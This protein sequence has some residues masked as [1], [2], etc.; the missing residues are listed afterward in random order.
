MGALS[1]AAPLALAALA[2]LPVIWWLLRVTPPAPQRLR[3]FGLRFLAGLKTE[4]E[5]PDKTPLW[6]L[7]LRMAAAAL[8]ILALA[9]PLM[10]ASRSLTRSDG[11]LILVVDNGWAAAHRWDERRDEMRGL[12]EEARRADLPV[13][14]APTASA[15]F[16]IRKE[17]PAD[18]LARAMALEPQPFRSD[19]SAMLARLSAAATGMNARVV[20]LADGIGDSDTGEIVTD[21]TGFGETA[22]YLDNDIAPAFAML[23]PTQDETGLTAHLLRAAPGPAL[24]GNVQAFGE[25]GRFIAAAPFSFASGEVK[26]EARIETPGALRNDIERLAVDSRASAGSVTLLDE[27]ARRRPVG[28]VSGDEG[29]G[30]Q[31]LLSA[32]YY[33]ERAFENAAEARLGTVSEHLDRGISMLVL[34]DVGQVTGEEETRLADWIDKGGVLIRFAGPRLAG[35]G[36]DD[37][38][39]VRLRQTGARALG[40]ALSWE[41]PQTLAPFPK[42]GPF[43]GLKAPD[44][45]AITRQVLAEP[46]LELESRTWAS[47]ADGTPLVTGVKRG[48]GWIVLFHITANAEWSNLPLS[49]LFVDMLKRLLSL[50]RGVG[51]SADQANAAGGSLNPRLVLDGFGRLVK[52]GA[53]VTPVPRGGAEIGPEHPPGLYGEGASTLALNLFAAD[54]TLMPF[55]DLPAGAS[56]HAYGQRTEI[57]FKPW[58]LGAALLLFFID[59]FASMMLRGYRFGIRRPTATTA[60]LILAAAIV[61][62]AAPP[63]HAQ[64]SDAAADEFALKAALQTHLA[65]VI[66]GDPELDR[67]SKEG[68]MGLTR[69]LDNRTAVSAGEPIGVDLE[70]DDLAFFPLLYYPIPDSGNLPSDAAIQRIDAYMKNGG[71]I[72]FDSRDG[73]NGGPASAALQ[74]IL[75]KLDLPPLQRV[76]REHVLT[77]AF[78][79]LSIFPGRQADGDVWVEAQRADGEPISEALGDGVSSVVIGAGDWAAA[80]AADD[81]MRPLYAMG[82]GGERQREYAYRF[83]VNLVMY[84][85]TGNYKADQVHVPALL[86]RMGQ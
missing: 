39:P 53:A 75:R 11:A 43:A 6:L 34:A 18:A 51:T 23:P 78:Y 45:I 47:L 1:F 19:R 76:P 4:E 79:L 24:S 22:I 36:G 15:D 69:V 12:I 28:I 60:A 85:L 37:L 8:V 13:I 77:K 72:L 52:P 68:L 20:W 35:G 67:M 50:G 29:Q 3:F 74:D 46:S 57:A 63:A 38:L 66:T 16:D 56:P 84:A 65:Y 62:P 58:L 27:S 40:G 48:E 32:T 7:I 10:N 83:G 25:G 61:L 17:D 70:K 30:G 49:G 21:L 80:W 33:L 14:L 5:T 42:A 31:P 26:T 2:A 81:Y 71:T 41:K 73:A 82:A 44:D 86:E 54:A 9:E 64:E 55:P 59:A